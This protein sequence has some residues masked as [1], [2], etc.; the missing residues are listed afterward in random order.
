M[1]TLQTYILHLDLD[2]FFV[3]VERIL[4]PSLNGKPVIVG[5][6]GDRGVVS[7]CSYEARQYGVRSAMSF[8]M[9][10]RLCPDGVYLKGTHD[11]YGRYSAMVT[12]IIAAEAPLF[13]KASIDEFY[14]DLTGMDKFYGCWKWS[15]ALRQKIIRETGLPISFGLAS[16]KMMAKMATNEAK[17]NGQLM[18]K[19]GE[20]QAFLD[21]MPIGKI[22]FCGEKTEKFL[23]EKGIKTIYELRQFSVEALQNWMGK[24]GIDLWNR[25]HGKSSVSLHPYHDP[26]GM[27][28]ERT[29]GQDSNNTEWLKRIL[30]SLTEKLTHDLR[31]EHKL[32]SCVAI[33]IRYQNFETH[34]KQMS[35]DA[36]SNTKILQEKVLHLFNSF[37]N[38]N[39]KVRLLGVRFSN[40]EEGYYQ[41]N[42]FED[43]EK[44]VMLFKAIDE[45]KNKYG[46]GKL[47]IAQ[48][49]NEKDIRN[50]PK[51]VLD[52]ESKRERSKFKNRD[53]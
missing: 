44:D 19:P 5:G 21:P 11:E 46:K 36:T 6:T 27:S 2:S 8:K 40:L 51:A 50:D 25:A 1:S 47:L 30:I 42:M 20:E 14:I 3:S 17:P 13:E 22:P 12:D 33:K 52:K 37:Y 10:Q 18:I 24:S 49:L 23:N 39:N 4:D 31:S 48:N 38:S 16:N 45:M 15:V 29:F 9:A 26:K 35:V 43:R 32:T 41:I 53:H 34:T 7:S 28:A